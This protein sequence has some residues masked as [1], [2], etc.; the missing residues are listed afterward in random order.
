MAK[1]D[2]QKL[3]RAELLEMLVE[4]TQRADRL[5]QEL[6]DAKARLIVREHMLEQALGFAKIVAGMLKKFQRVPV[7]VNIWQHGD[8]TEV[9]GQLT[10]HKKLPAESRSQESRTL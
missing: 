10:L 4:Q 7:T 2:L 8:K 5:Q 1:S 6:D 9:Q 3:S